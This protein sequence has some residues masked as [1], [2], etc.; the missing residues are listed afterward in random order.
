MLFLIWAVQW[1]PI[2]LAMTVLAGLVAQLLRR[3][4]SGTPPDKT[5]LIACG[6]LVA[7]SAVW[8]IV[9]PFGVQPAFHL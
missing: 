8:F 6:V 2:L 1:G 5:R 7:F 9:S 4:S 3:R